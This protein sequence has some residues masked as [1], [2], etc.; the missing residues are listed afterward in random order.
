MT[1]S[2]ILRRADLTD[3]R[4]I[5]YLE[6]VNDFLFKR[7][8]NLMAVTPITIIEDDSVKKLITKNERKLR[9]KYLKTR[10]IN[11]RLLKELSPFQKAMSIIFDVLCALL[12]VFSCLI[13]TSSI[14]TAS[15]NLPPTFFGYTNLTVVSPSMQ[16]SGINVGD[17]VLVKNVDTDT[18][19][20]GDIIAFYVDPN[21]YNLFNIDAC[22]KV[23]DSDIGDLTY[24]TT[25][26]T[27]FG[28]QNQTIL[29]A[30]NYNRKLVLHH[31]YDIYQD[32]NGTRYFKTMGS[33]N[34][35]PDS[36]VISENAILGA[37]VNTPT[38]GFITGASSIFSSPFGYLLLLLPMILCGVLILVEG[39]KDINKYKLEL[40][41][42]EEKRKITDLICVKNDIGYN[43][44]S[45]NK[46][47]ILAQAPDDRR[48]EYISLLWRSHTVPK[49]VRKYVTRRNILLRYNK[50]LL[51]LNRECEQML[52]KGKDPSQIATYYTT[53]KQQILDAQRSL[54]KTLRQKAI[55]SSNK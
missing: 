2:V 11:S 32:L 23:K 39:F 26:L 50:Q 43:M 28:V 52:K 7:K 5:S 18:L 46:L 3:Y 31:V 10:N 37:M 42:I 24:N 14:I 49:G 1:F 45:K 21:D 41:C 16:K 8:A 44:S 30:S 47:K 12:M 36:W 25:L 53:T 54:A 27:F 13:C 6:D 48:D 40:D 34:P 51:T 29:N 17:R 38:A 55:N 35:M 33:S 15:Q 4:R 20:R 9:R 19:R 22:F